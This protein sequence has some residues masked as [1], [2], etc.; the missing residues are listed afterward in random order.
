MGLEQDKILTSSGYKRINH[1]NE[2]LAQ[3]QGIEST[4]IPD[5]IIK[6]VSR[7][8]ELRKINENSKV[9]ISLIKEI[10][11]I[12]GFTN[13]YEHSSQLLSILTGSKVPTFTSNQ[14]YELKTMFNLCQYPYDN[15]PIEIRKDSETGKVRKNFLTYEY[16]LFKMCELLGYVEF[17]GMFNLLKSIKK[18]NKHDEIWKYICE[19]NEW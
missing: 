16:V 4:V 6:Y 1:F 5:E 7:E 10:L 13:F 14:L 19:Y 8:L 3:K 17:N 9:K 18:L 2:W 11:K 15:C 12:G